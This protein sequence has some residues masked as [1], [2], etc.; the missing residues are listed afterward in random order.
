M[1]KNMYSLMLSKHIIDEI[2]RICKKEN[3]TRSALIN[4][5]LAEKLNLKTPENRINNIF[6]IID[7]IFKPSKLECFFG[8]SSSIELKR[9]LNYK[10]KPTL[11][12]EFYLYKNYLRGPIG[13]L[14]VSLRTTSEELINEI[15]EFLS[16]FNI[17]ENYFIEDMNFQKSQY[18]KIDTVKYKREFIPF[19][20][21][22][23]KD[24]EIANYV[25]QYI[26]VFDSMLE[27]FINNNY[28][29]IEQMTS[30]YINKFKKI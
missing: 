14:R 22:Q 5:I 25:S 24:E 12:Y 23:I 3:K 30:D 8:D 16:Y 1:K 26:K 19:I 2:D 10:Y 6:N 18:K 28:Y 11:K 20:D 17:L 29:S 4:D 15:E 7:S 21:L 27:D 13:E 9:A